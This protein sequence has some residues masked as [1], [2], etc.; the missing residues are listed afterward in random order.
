MPYEHFADIYDGF[1]ADAPYDDWLKWLSGLNLSGETVADVGCGT[2][3]LALELARRGARLIGVDVA[4]TMLSTAAARA[5]REHLRITWLCQDMRELSLPVP[6]DLLLSTCDSLNYLVTRDDLL[7][8]FRRFHEFL[9]PS[10]LFCFDMLGPDRIEKLSEGVWFD[11][12]DDAEVWFTS[13]V[14]DDGR[15]E[16][17]VHAFFEDG[18]RPGLYRKFVE[19]HVEQFYSEKAVRAVLS[20]AGFEVVEMMGD[21]GR[22]PSSSADR[23]V[24]IARKIQA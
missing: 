20:E 23:I 13:D 22:T 21:F 8:A 24:V 15:I 2:G 16:Y 1:M 19:R 11:L 12:R 9:R 14:D 17:E 5:A 10:G 18:E 4:S 6:V 3:T 7:G